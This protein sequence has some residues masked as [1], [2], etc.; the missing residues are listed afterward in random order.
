MIDNN[1]F[2]K[3]TDFGLSKD[4]MNR[5]KRAFT[6]TGTSEFMAPEVLEQSKE[7]YDFAYDWW[8]FGCVLYDLLCGSTP[9]HSMNCNILKQNILNS[10]PKFP[11]HITM[12]ARSII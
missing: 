5:K 1:G 6:L 12:E 8:S 10:E 2:L 4:G 9:F 7:G 11:S 3:L